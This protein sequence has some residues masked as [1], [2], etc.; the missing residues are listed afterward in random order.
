M[1]KCVRLTRSFHVMFCRHHCHFPSV[2]FFPSQRIP[3]ST[4]MTYTCIY[5]IW[6]FPKIGVPQNGWF[7][8]ENPI[9]MDDLG[10]PLC[11]LII[12]NTHIHMYLQLVDNGH[13]LFS[14]YFQATVEAETPAS[15]AA[16]MHWIIEDL[17][18]CW[19]YGKTAYQAMA[20]V[21]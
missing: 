7:I 3:F 1:T 15:D 16:W 4:N 6:M 2:R 19:R 11:T 5:N 20:S 14:G 13:C 8:M 10:V 17:K 18:G 12:G 9:K 21:S